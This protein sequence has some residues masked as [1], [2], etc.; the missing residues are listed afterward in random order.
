MS[1]VT[2]F[3]NCRSF[4][5]DKSSY[6]SRD[7]LETIFS[8]QVGETLRDIQY[9]VTFLSKIR[10]CENCLRSPFFLAQSLQSFVDALS[11]A[12]NAKL[13]DE[14]EAAIEA[15]FDAVANEA[16][17]LMAES[18]NAVSKRFNMNDGE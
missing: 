13:A 15:D 8:T 14:T 12:E 17:E 3:K 4:P 18:D 10:E 7:C 1:L 2:F 16:F 9:W 5:A 6:N 11:Q